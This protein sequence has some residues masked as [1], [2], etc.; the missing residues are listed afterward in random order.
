MTK[1]MYLALLGS[2]LISGR[3]PEVAQNLKTVEEYVHSHGGLQAE[4]FVEGPGLY[5]RCSRLPLRDDVVFASLRYRPG[6]TE[7]PQ[8]LILEGDDFKHM[9]RKS[10]KGY[11]LPDDVSPIDDIPFLLR[12]LTREI[13]FY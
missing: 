6:S 10:S 7:D 4:I 12:N 5:K 9:F 1:F 3:D 11:Q 13:K 8:T 2:S